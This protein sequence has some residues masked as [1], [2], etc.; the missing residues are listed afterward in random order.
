MPR[1][2]IGVASRLCELI[3]H[4]AA[5][6]DEAARGLYRS[7]A[8]T[9]LHPP[10]RPALIR[11]FEAKHDFT[12]P[13]S[14]RIFLE[15]HN[16]WERY[17]DGYTLIGVSGRH[18]HRA[19][20]DIRQTV[21]AFLDAWIQTYGTPTPDTIRAYESRG[22]LANRW[23]ATGQPFVAEK[24]HFGTN[25]N[26]GLRFFDPARH[27]ADGEMEVLSWSTNAGTLARYPSF[28]DMLQGDLQRLQAELRAQTQRPTR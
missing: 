14:Y 3:R 9:R 1:D 19:L 15:W 2:R 4:M 21:A 10:A 11:A 28:V 26:G 23:E 6:S 22:N 27:Y 7:K 5:A 24:I 25:F 16:G 17:A 13:P 8:R 12:F 18:T 20:A